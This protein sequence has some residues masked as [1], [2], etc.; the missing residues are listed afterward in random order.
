[1]PHFLVVMT[2]VLTRS[3]PSR[4]L[5]AVPECLYAALGALCMPRCFWIHS[6]CRCCTFSACWVILRLPAFTAVRSGKHVAVP[7]DRFWTN[8]LIRTLCSQTIDGGI[9]ACSTTSLLGL[10]LIDTPIQI[11][12]TGFA[13]IF[14]WSTFSFH[15]WYSTD[16]QL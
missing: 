4:H 6:T 7:D 15:S 11:L 14:D 5:A 13:V 9:G 2:S 16:F 8:S 1:M 10:G 12:Y 3:G